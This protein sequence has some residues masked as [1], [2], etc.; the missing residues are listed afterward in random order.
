MVVMMKLVARVRVTLM[1][2]ANEFVRVLGSVVIGY[3]PLLET[4]QYRRQ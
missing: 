3:E 1:G 4:E 2:S